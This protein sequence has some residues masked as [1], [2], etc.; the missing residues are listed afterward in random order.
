MKMLNTVFLSMDE[1]CILNDLV[2]RCYN[3]HSDEITS[4]DTILKVRRIVDVLS[5]GCPVFMEARY[6][7]KQ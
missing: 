4:P 2:L 6:E 5:S 7:P 1:S 3:E